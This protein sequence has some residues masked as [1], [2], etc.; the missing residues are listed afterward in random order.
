MSFTPDHPST[1]SSGNESKAMILDSEMMSTGLTMADSAESE[2]ITVV[3]VKSTSDLS[4]EPLE[5]LSIT[6]A[7]DKNRETMTNRKSGLS[8]TFG[9]SVASHF[10][11][12]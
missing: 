12:L 6:D 10:V 7:N 5:S 9:V 2:G 4:K 3:F 11:A 8:L 1:E